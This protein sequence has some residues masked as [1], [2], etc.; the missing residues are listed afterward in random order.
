V[1]DEHK[2][3][4]LALK[5]DLR[6]IPW[7]FAGILGFLVVLGGVTTAFYGLPFAP[8]ADLE[9]EQEHSAHLDSQ[10]AQLT[11]QVQIE[12]QNLAVLTEIVK[13]TQD[14]TTRIMDTVEDLQ[15]IEQQQALHIEDL[16]AGEKARETGSGKFRERR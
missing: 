6:T 7:L 11:S 10:L 4:E 5:V 9:R 13:N 1:M 14:T 15:K 8:K 12:A 2:H 3:G 16:E